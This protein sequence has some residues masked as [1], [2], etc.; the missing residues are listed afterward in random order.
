MSRRKALDITLTIVIGVA[1]LL[2]SRLLRSHFSA[3]AG[4]T[5]LWICS[6]IAMLVAGGLA[7]RRGLDPISWMIAFSVTYLSVQIIMQAFV[8]GGAL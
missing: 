8:A 1:S 7:A 3:P 2:V 6:A 4:D 5:W